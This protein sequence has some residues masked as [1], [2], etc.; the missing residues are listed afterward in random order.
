MLGQIIF[1][2]LIGFA[3]GFA[4]ATWV[5]VWIVKGPNFRLPW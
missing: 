3:I 2:G 4:A 5:A 1:G